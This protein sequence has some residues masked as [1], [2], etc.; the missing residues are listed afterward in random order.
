MNGMFLNSRGLCDLAKHVRI[1]DFIRDHSLDFVGISETGKRD[2]TSSLLNRLSGGVDF[3][4]ISRP[5]RGR[6]GGLLL[7]VRK[8][9]MDVLTSSDGDFH[10]KVN[11]RNKVDN[12]TWSLVTVYGAAQDKFKP[13]FL[14]EVVNLAKDN[15][16]PIILGGDFNL[17]RFS[18]EK[19]RGR[20]DTHWPFLFNAVIDSLDLRE[21]TMIGRQF[22]WANSLPE[23]TYEKLDRV[24]MDSNWESKYPLV[25]VRVLERIEALSDHA[26]ILLTTGTPRPQGNRQFKFELGW[27]QREG[28]SE[29]VKNVWDRHVP[30]QTPI[31]RWNNKMR[32]LRKHLGGWARHMAGLLKMEKLRLSSI[33]DELESFSEV[34]P[35]SPHEL[36]IKNQCNAEIAGLLREEELK[37][38]QRSKAQ[39]ILEGDSNTRYFHSLANGRYRKKRIYSLN[40][41]EG[42]IED[43]EQLKT[44]I[45]NY[46][47]NLFGKPEEGNFSMDESRTDDIPQVS[48]EI[49]RAH[50]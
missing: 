42:L 22:T 45:T 33:I 36:E 37:W 19:S 50:V 4:W 8:D 5:P 27:L 3:T 7:G 30:G 29:M 15:P 34:R 47:K 10:I 13:A 48:D 35:L 44:Y 40:Q 43:H 49:G 32:A 41:D 6:S 1:A 14:R 12:F 28:F 23:P 24:L 46:Y 38:Y 25:S 21:V 31:E 17:L 20:F 11:I 18:H 9:T 39:F 2:F 26:P 16:F